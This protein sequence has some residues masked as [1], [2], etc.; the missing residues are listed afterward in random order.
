MDSRDNWYPT[1]I[2]NW[3]HSPRSGRKGNIFI[4]SNPKA[5]KKHAK[6]VMETVKKEKRPPHHF[7]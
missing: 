5:F 1:I 6:D 7:P 3:D 2:P 4:N